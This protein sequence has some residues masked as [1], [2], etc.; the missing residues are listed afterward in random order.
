MEMVSI[1]KFRLV[2]LV[3]DGIRYQIV[4]NYSTET[5]LALWL[6]R[7]LLASVSVICRLY[8]SE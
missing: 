1:Q 3:S 2:R 7:P 6:H 5:C 4:I 8:R